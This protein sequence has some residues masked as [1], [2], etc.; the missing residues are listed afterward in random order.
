MR[1]TK[2]SDHEVRPGTLVEWHPIPLCDPAPDPRPASYVQE[3]HVRDAVARRAAGLSCPAWL[4]TAFELPGDLDT[5]ALRRA[6]LAWIDRH[7]TL[8]STLTFPAGAGAAV[9]VRRLTLPAGG[10]GLRRKDRGPFD[11]VTAISSHVE[12]L[13]DRAATPLHWP[14]YV[15]ATVSRPGT[16]TIYLGLDHS[17]VDGYSILLIAQ[18]V[19]AL[20]TAALSG[21]A[22]ELTATGSY[23]EFSTAE[24]ADAVRVRAD[25]ESITRWRNFLD[26]NGGRLPGFPLEVGADSARPALQHGSC[27]WLLDADKA[28]SFSAACRAA[29]G[30][31]QAGVLAC[32][33]IAGHEVSARRAF[34]ALVPFHTRQ[35]AEWTTSLGWYV[36][37]AP[38]AFP[39]M[40]APDFAGLIR[41]VGAAARA[42]R[43]LARVPFARVCELLDS[44]PQPRFVVSYGHAQHT[45]RGPVATVA[46]LR[47]PQ[48][49][50]RGGRGV[51]VDSPHPRRRL[52]DLSPPRHRSR[53]PQ[54]HSLYRPPPPRSR[55]GRHARR[56][57]RCRVAADSHGRHGDHLVRTV[58]K[59]TPSC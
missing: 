43:P 47:L 25:H 11:Q 57:R 32:L 20:Y 35:G 46:H 53:N 19:R 56:L 26:T 42:A 54:R 1:F 17:N 4:A 58:R 52:P 21:A 38:V 10:V 6:L 13:F 18:E 5:A 37:V 22:A 7:E 39:V 40:G 14:P 27:T 9:Q 12:A 34:R 41:T 36:G 29:G 16:T 49:V 44:N 50:V 2:L 24:R 31:F 48:Q 23:L 55:R 15:F 3:A 28:E 45:G 51:P 30:G 8:R 59:G 33:G